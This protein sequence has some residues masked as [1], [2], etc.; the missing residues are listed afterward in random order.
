MS[1]INM[2]NGISG[3]AD[4]TPRARVEGAGAAQIY[5]PPLLHLRIV[6][7]SLHRRWA[8]LSCSHTVKPPQRTFQHRDSDKQTQRWCWL[9]FVWNVS[10]H[11]SDPQ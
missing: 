9:N 8:L 7:F 1:N 3:A 4:L 2:I 11:E 10:V 5:G 6:A